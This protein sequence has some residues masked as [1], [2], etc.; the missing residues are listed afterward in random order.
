MRKYALATALC[1][2]VLTGTPARAEPIVLSPSSPWN[3]DFAEDKCRLM[4]FF[5]E[6]DDR[7]YLLFQQYWP[8]REAGLTVA[9]PSFRKFRSLYRT[10]VRFFDGQDPVRTTPFTGTVDG[11]GTGVIFSSLSIREAQPEAGTP[12]ESS[13]RGPAQLDPAFGKKVQ[14][15]ELKQG[16]REVRLDTGPLN[17][18]FDVLNQCT[19]DLLRDWGLDPERHLTASSGPQWLNQE[20]LARRIMAN[21]PSDALAR[22]EQGIMRMRVIVSADGAVESCT[23][24]KATETERLESPAC[25]VMKAAKFEPARDAAGQPFR[26]YYA[27]SITYRGG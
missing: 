19:L 10:D 12:E 6:G 23:M 13:P 4:R 8:A 18:A 16:G 21:Y 11:F 20:A 17:A 2:T 1:A 27:T 25:N 24:L 3:V 5:G 14:F 7:H 9:G 26:S 15:L 22:G